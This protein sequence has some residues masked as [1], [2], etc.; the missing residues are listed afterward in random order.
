MFVGMDVHKDA[1]QV[2]CVDGNGKVLEK[3]RIP[4]SL[5][6]IDGLARRLPPGAK[7]AL[8]AG[9]V[10][11]PVH[12]WLRER[13][14]EV[15]MAN[16]RRLRLV[17]DSKRKTDEEDSA[18]L[19]HLLRMNYLPESY[20]PD[21]ETQQ[22]RGLIQ[23][24]VA[25]GQKVNAAKNQVHALLTR[26]GI[27]HGFADLF[28][29]KGSGFLR[30]VRLPWADQLALESH[31][32]ELGFLGGEIEALV[33]QIAQIARKDPRVDLLMTI[34]GIG[35]YSA[36]AI[37]SAIGDIHRFPNHRSLVGYAGLAPSIHQSGERAHH[38]HITKEGPGVLRWILVC[39][40]HGAVKRE[41]KL[42]RFYLRLSRRIGKNKATVATARKMLVVIY[43]ML[44][45]D[46]P[47][48][49]RHEDLLHQKRAKLRS[50]AT[51]R[52]PRTNTKR[53]EELRQK[54]IETLISQDQGLS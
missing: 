14:V 9:T 51:A 45:D 47:Y 49:E 28:G 40:A 44:K 15:H 54:G 21:E 48:E 5:E 35:H 38:G 25:L 10:S 19:A 20:V 16:P 18:I 11:R 50:T 1:C 4:T 37:L 2:T 27:R 52:R 26:N 31:L 33:T 41:G 36:L 17:A 42:Q 24:R 23:H 46:K 43:H 32:R 53:H 39:A 13:G 8:E 22:L 34:P 3:N 7:V 30:E 6:S 12:K 29:S